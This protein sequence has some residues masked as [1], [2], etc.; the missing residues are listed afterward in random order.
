MEPKHAL[1]PFSVF[2]AGEF[3]PCSRR[4]FSCKDY[5]TKANRPRVSAFRPLHATAWHGSRQQ[6]CQESHAQICE[7]RQGSLPERR[8]KQWQDVQCLLCCEEVQS[9]GDWHKRLQQSHERLVQAI[10]DCIQEVWREEL[11][12]KLA[13]RDVRHLEA[14]TRG[15]LRHMLLQRQA[16]QELPLQEL[17][18]MQELLQDIEDAERQEDVLLQQ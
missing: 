14:W 3:S 6:H 7:L 4:H 17:R 15:L 16:G 10:E 18:A 9:P 11:S 13:C 1:F 5:E 12:A 8:Y 2:I